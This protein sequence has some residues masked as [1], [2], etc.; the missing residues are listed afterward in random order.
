MEAFPPRSHEVYPTVGRTG[1]RCCNRATGDCS[2]RQ[3]AVPASRWH[4]CL[5]WPPTLRQ[6]PLRNLSATWGKAGKYRSVERGRIGSDWRCFLEAVMAVCICCK[7]WWLF[8]LSVE[9]SEKN[10]KPASQKERRDGGKLR[11]TI[12]ASAKGAHRKVKTTPICVL[13]RSNSQKKNSGKLQRKR[14]ILQKRSFF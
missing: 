4:P 2:R 11:A 1:P 14:A 12:E 9:R 8:F 7:I 6:G 10:A 13:Q 3:S 5:V